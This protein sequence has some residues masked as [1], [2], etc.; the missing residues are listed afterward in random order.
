MNWTFQLKMRNYVI[1][2][3]SGRKAICLFHKYKLTKFLKTYKV[4]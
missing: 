2:E 1:Q 4:L 3:K